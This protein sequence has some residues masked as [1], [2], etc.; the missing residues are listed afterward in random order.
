MTSFKPNS[1]DEDKPGLVNPWVAP[2][3]DPEHK[4]YLSTAYTESLKDPAQQPYSNRRKLVTVLV[5][6]FILT[7]MICA[8][9][10]ENFYLI[11]RRDGIVRV[12]GSS[13]WAYVITFAVFSSGIL[14]R[15]L[16][17]A[18]A[19]RPWGAVDFGLLML[20]CILLAAGPIWAPRLF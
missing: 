16:S 19:S 8:V 13:A 14:R 15:V 1:E 9:L 2:P 3:Y 10:T 4:N 18:P 11:A 12:T 20:G 5:I 17:M 6:V 7:V